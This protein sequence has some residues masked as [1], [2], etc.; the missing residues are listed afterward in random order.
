MLG[1]SP[2]EKWHS[3]INIERFKA[4]TGSFLEQAASVEEF[5]W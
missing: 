4:R 5:F 3:S 1:N 2:Q